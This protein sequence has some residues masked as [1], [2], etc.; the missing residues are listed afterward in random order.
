[1]N[2]LQQSLLAETGPNEAYY[3]SFFLLFLSF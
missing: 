1:M 2:D 3:V